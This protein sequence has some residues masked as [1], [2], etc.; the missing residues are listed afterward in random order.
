MRK[1]CARL[2]DF[3]DYKI[4]SIN[5]IALVVEAGITKVENRECCAFREYYDDDVMR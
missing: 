1:E 3:A 2:S 5:K 4:L